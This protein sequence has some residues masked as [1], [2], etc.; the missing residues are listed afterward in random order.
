MRILGG[1]AKGRTLQVP[2]SARPTGARLRKSLF[3][4]LAGHYG[5]GHRFLDLY[6]G[7]GAVGLEAASRGFEVT[8]LDRDPGAVRALETNARNLGL[9]ARILRSDA[10]SF[11]RRGGSFDV[12]FVDPPY[13]QDIPAL[14]AAALDAGLLAPGGVLI[15]Q[16]PV[17]LH[18]EAR[19]GLDLERREYGSNAISLYWRPEE[20]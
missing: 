8:L 20:A 13:P 3:D 7:S 6:A 1:T 16:H 17:Q 19:E 9:S 10:Q 2:A 14:A 5:E 4:L 15:V 11:L 12:I 18:L